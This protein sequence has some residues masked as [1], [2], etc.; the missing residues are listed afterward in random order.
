MRTW[1]KGGP[2][3]V[4]AA[5]AQARENLP[6]DRFD[7]AKAFADAL[8]NPAFRTLTAAAAG[9]A[10]VS[11]RSRGTVLL[12]A[13]L[14]AESALAT[15]HEEVQARVDAEAA[16]AASDPYPSMAQA[17]DSVFAS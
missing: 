3:N 8:T 1:G 15:L 6:A 4:A 14:V 5:L 10:G 12:A 16:L 13:G 9:A 2:G 11:T 17:R 7:S